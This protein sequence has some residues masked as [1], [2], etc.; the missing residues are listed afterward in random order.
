M[1]DTY[2]NTETGEIRGRL[3]LLSTSQKKGHK[4]RCPY[5]APLAATLSN[6]NGKI[7]QCCCNHWECPTCGDT[8]AK[9]E[10]HRIVYGAQEL[11]K[12]HDLYFVTLTCRGKEMPIEVAEESYY[13]WTNRLLSVYRAHV[14]AK[15][16]YWS[17]VQVTERQK[18][19]RQ[20][21][22][23]H[24]LITA[25][26]NDAK[27]TSDARG[28]QHYV[29][30]LFTKWNASAG[31]GNQHKIT[32]V[33]SPEAVSRYV[34]KYLFKQSAKD[35]FPKKWKRVRYSANYP[36]KPEEKTTE[37]WLLER[38]DDWDRIADMPVFWD[39]TIESV[40]QWAKH[41]YGNIRLTTDE[42]QHVL[43]S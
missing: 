4:D 6:G 18:K 38:V 1:R 31:L 15:G 27:A 19:T 25:L 35:T 33:S 32:R 5:G 24:I 29:S 34:A 13:E 20:H 16:G 12:Q 30:S 28:K 36:R 22:H 40:Y 8:R 21:P 2:L 9:Q 17:Y 7:V 42:R 14:R 23:S 3:D 10:Y 26:P 43:V 39:T 37:S 41:R 11:A